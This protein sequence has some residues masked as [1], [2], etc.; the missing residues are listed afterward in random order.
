MITY[1]SLQEIFVI[2]GIILFL[3]LVLYLQFKPRKRK[4]A[5][6]ETT[7]S[8]P[9]SCRNCDIKAY[10]KENKKGDQ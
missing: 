3:G 4:K 2:I 8:C 9:P 7:T 6:C 1:I 5:C 10:L